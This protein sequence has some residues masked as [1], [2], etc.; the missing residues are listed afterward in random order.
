MLVCLVSYVRQP[1]TDSGTDDR[2]RFVTFSFCVKH[3]LRKTHLTGRIVRKSS[4]CIDLFQGL[5]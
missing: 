2:H 1:V 4:A 5:T 3:G